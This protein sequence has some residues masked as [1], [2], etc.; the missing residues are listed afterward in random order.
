MHCTPVQHYCFSCEH[1]FYPP[2]RYYS[3]QSEERFRTLGKSKGQRKFRPA[4][5]YRRFSSTSRNERLWQPPLPHNFAT[6]ISRTTSNEAQYLKLVSLIVVFRASPAAPAASAT[7]Q[8]R[9]T[10]ASNCWTFGE[11]TPHIVHSSCDRCIESL[12]ED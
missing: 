2:I 4:A 9:V 10:L 1:T 6:F 7:P 12:P 5:N 11:S 3:Y 8:H